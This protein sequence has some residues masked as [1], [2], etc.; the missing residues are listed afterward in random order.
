MNNSMI[1]RVYSW[2]KNIMHPSAKRQTGWCE[3]LLE[4]LNPV[5]DTLENII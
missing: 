1:E 2:M 4:M 5:N 3:D